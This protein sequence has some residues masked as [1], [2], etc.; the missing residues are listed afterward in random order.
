MLLAR[1]VLGGFWCLNVALE[2]GSTQWA[3][4]FAAPATSAAGLYLLGLAVW[5]AARRAQVVPASAP[6]RVRMVD[7]A[8]WLVRVAWPAL[9]LL[10]GLQWYF[11][12]SGVADD[13]W[14]PCVGFLFA[15]LPLLPLAFFADTQDA[16]PDRRARP[17]GARLPS[18]PVVL[19]V[20]A[21]LAC[22]CALLADILAVSMPDE[23]RW[24]WTSHATAGWLRGGVFAQLLL[25]AAAGA[26]VVESLLDG[27]WTRAR[28]GLV[29]SAWLT[30]LIAWRPLVDERLKHGGLEGMVLA[31]VS[32]VPLA[33][34][35]VLLA[36]RGVARGASRAWLALPLAAPVVQHVLAA[37]L[38]ARHGLAGVGEAGQ[39]ALGGVVLVL[40]VREAV[41]WRRPLDVGDKS[42]GDVTGTG[43]AG[44]EVVE[45]R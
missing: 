6:S 30:S 45:L 16:A 4:G 26:C 31:S 35:A 15:G 44:P 41:T 28:L 2:V 19:A 10:L 13:D 5:G 39:W 33:V 36:A 14:E 27:R 3:A 29:A 20:L 23:L 9:P 37:P 11:G 38:A 42:A 17:G 1:V 32:L 22:A 25:G 40:V 34:L 43:R 24:P 12:D 18:P 8:P 7:S 21:P